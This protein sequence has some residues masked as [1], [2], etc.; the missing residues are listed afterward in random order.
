M[1][2]FYKLN[3]P[4]EFL[5]KEIDL[6]EYLNN[7]NGSNRIFTVNTEKFVNPEAI[8]L[9][10]SIG[11]T[12]HTYSYLF[13]RKPL[14]TS[15]IHTDTNGIIPRIWAIN[16][17]WGSDNSDMSWYEVIDPTQKKKTLL[18]AVNSGYLVYKSNEIK[19]IEQYSTSGL[20]ITRT[21]IP[22]SVTNYDS[23]NNRWCIS[24][25]ILDIFYDW[26]RVIKT[27]EPFIK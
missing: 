11:L 16:Y 6:S 20:F 19:K 14:E 8:C 21:D 24:I 22:H 18:T 7:S 1:T 25:R 26:N 27:L 2:C 10:E 12:P 23:I 13:L 9:L 4:V 15:A 5:N 3:F 17:T